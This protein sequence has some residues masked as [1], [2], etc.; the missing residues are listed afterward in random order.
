MCVCVCVCVCVYVRVWVR[1][2][3][4]E[5]EWEKFNYLITERIIILKFLVFK[6]INED[7]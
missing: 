1:L 2:G 5:K 4:Y 6:K 7:K 3:S